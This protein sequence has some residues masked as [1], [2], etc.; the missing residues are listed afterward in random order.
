MINEVKK[1][2]TT[3]YPTN[4][5]KKTSSWKGTKQMAID[6]N[7]YG[8]SVS[9]LPEYKEISSADAIIQFKGKWK[10]ADFKYSDTAN[11][12]T[13][14]EDLIHGFEQADTIV[15]K[16]M[17]GD[18]GTFR[19]II[20]QMQRKEC[21]IGNICLINK[22]GKIKFLDSIELKNKKYQNIIRGFL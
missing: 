8:S 14:A 10:I 18:A 1:A 13:I 15:L 11:H 4:H 7:N 20:E 5:G 3:L 6:L 19:R 21:H 9:F 16:M 22:Y 2:K 17:K 12:N